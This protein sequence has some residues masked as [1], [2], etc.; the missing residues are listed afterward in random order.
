MP[1]FAGYIP[2]ELDPEYH[3]TYPPKN[4]YTKVTKLTTNRSI[5]SMIPTNATDLT[6]DSY[7]FPLPKEG[8]VV[9]HSGRW[10]D[11]QLGRI[12]FLRYLDKKECYFAE[13]VPLKE[14]KAA[15]IFVIDAAGKT[16]Y[17]SVNEVSPVRAVFLRKENG[18]KVTFKEGTS[19]PVLRA[20]RYRK[21]D[22]ATYTPPSKVCF[23]Y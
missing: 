16:D 6:E 18:Y 15:N 11:R 7:S 20:P 9:Y 19:E 13:I 1:R 22:K 8:D 17:L 4:K 21:V 5:A 10:G 14:G 3:N 2:P 12:R 23:M